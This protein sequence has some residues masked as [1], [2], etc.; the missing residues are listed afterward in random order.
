MHLI[1]ADERLS[2]EAVNASE[3]AS[4]ERSTTPRLPGHER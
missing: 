1:D 4:A 3:P 2:A